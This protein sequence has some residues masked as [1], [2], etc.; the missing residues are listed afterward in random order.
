MGVTE[1]R[2]FLSVAPFSA[3]ARLLFHRPG[4]LIVPAQDTTAF[5][6]LILA[7]LIAGEAC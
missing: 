2:P 6:S 4:K 1:R 3:L 5:Y 7:L